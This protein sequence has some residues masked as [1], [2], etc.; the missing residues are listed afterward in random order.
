MKDPRHTGG[1]SQD[2]AWGTKERL[3]HCLPKGDQKRGSDYKIIS[4]SLKSNLRVTLK[5]LRDVDFSYPPLQIPLWG[6]VTTPH[7][8]S[9]RRRAA[10]LLAAVAAPSSCRLDSTVASLRNRS[11]AARLAAHT[12]HISW[13]GLAIISTTY[14]SNVHSKH[15]T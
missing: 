3:L 7:Q 13:C 4:E 9:A 6:T 8:S 5:S 14:I 2:T 11:I 15:Q 12:C 10:P 1:V